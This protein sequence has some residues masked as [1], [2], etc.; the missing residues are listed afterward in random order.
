MTHFDPKEYWDE[1][2]RK[3]WGLLGVGYLGMGPSWNQWLYRVQRVVFLRAVRSLQPNF[4]G[5][6]VLEI[7]PGTGFYTHLWQAVGIK[8]LF[9]LDIST[10]AVRELSD[11]FPKYGFLQ[12]D[13]GEPEAFE[14][15]Q[16][17]APFDVVSAFAVLYHIVDDQKYARA[18]HTTANLLAP[19]G[20]FIFSENLIHGDAQVAEHQVSR[21]ID[22]IAELLRKNDLQ[23]IRRMPQFVLM[24]APVD[25]HSKLLQRY[26]KMLSTRVEKNDQF[27]GMTGALLYPCEILLTRLLK[28]GC[29]TE[30]VVCRKLS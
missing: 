8:S 30:V 1:R 9:G 21:S 23:I 5:A 29:S 26:W 6:R 28:E 7:G 27:G 22:A 15:A 2:L 14:V 16:E 24:N 18:F 13:I 11:R 4:E 20:T 10:F 17:M 19:E 3:S 25:S 12:A